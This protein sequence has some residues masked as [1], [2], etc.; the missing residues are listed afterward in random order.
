MHQPAHPGAEVAFITVVLRGG[1]HS[2][3]RMP[4]A[5]R[6]FCRRPPHV[7]H[8]DNAYGAVFQRKTEIALCQHQQR[9]EN[10]FHHRNG[11]HSRARWKTPIPACLPLVIHMIRPGPLRFRRI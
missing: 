5:S 10:V 11:D 1:S 9:R 8:P 7:A 6:R 4:N 2:R 3:V